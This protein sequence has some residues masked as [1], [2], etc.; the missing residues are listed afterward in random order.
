MRNRILLAAIC[1]GTLAGCS[2]KTL[3]LTNPNAATIL[4]ANA[5]PNA[6]QL[7]ATGLLSDFRAPRTGQMSGLGRLGR[8][9]YIFTPQEGRNTTNYLIGITVGSKQE[10]DPAGFITATW[11]YPALRNIYNFKSAIGANASLT[12]QQKS[13][14]LG[15]AKT[16]EAAQLL[17]II[18]TTDTLGLITQVLDDPTQPAPFV[19]R[20]S[21]YRYILA[22]F[23]AANAALA[24]GGG[25]FPF[26]LHSGFTGFNTPATFMK[27]TNALEARAAADY[28]TSGGGATAWQKAQTALAGSFLNMNA[29]SAADMNAG[30]YHVYSSAAGDV[31]NGIDPVTNT[32]LYAHMSYLTDAQSKADGTTDNRVLNK[33]VTG[34]G[35][36]QGPVTSSGPTSASSTIG[37][38][39][40]PTSAS[41]VPVIRNEE[42]ILLN[43]ETKLALGDLTGAIAALNVTRQV[44][45]GLPASTLTA[46][47]GSSAILD[48]ILYEKRYSLMF[49]GLRWVDMRRYGRLNQ[50]PLD[51]P[52]GPNKNFVAP[53]APIPQAECLTRARLS[54]AFL[55]PNGQNN[56]AP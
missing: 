18:I 17:G 9:S 37:F 53:V 1:A 54:G 11:N 34:L 6:L 56:C 13:A 38:K 39:I 55:G 50:L 25:A 51:V 47:S 3:Q 22:T 40:Y 15:F 19:S 49:E 33:I 20:D 44:S 46:A 14:A 36:R 32:T 35:T 7:T 28:A 2:D 4:G 8:E 52:S 30:V 31:L 27:L 45:G 29:A 24:A 23:D 26:T 41:P 42:L 43:A 5:D 10:L 12:A 16:F 21:A 48:Q